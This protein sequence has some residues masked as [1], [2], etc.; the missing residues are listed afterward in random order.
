MPKGE[1]VLTNQQINKLAL[2]CQ[3]KDTIR[4]L[5]D[6]AVGTAAVVGASIPGRPYAKISAMRR[7]LAANF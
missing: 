3:I 2:E 7:H 6:V 1:R 4:T 5:P